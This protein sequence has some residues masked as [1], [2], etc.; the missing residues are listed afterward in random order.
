MP[1]ERQWRSGGGEG[2]YKPTASSPW[3]DYSWELYSGSEIVSTEHPDYRT[4]G[5][6]DVGGY[7][8]LHK[9][10]VTTDPGY[11]ESDRFQGSITAGTN[12]FAPAVEPFQ[13]LTD[14]N[15]IA[16]GTDAI[17][18]VSPQPA[19]NLFT[20][21]GELVKDGIPSLLGANLWREQAHV[22][23]GAGKE[24]L[25]SEFGWLPLIRDV[26]SFAKA[27]VDADE[28][29]AQYRSD[30]GTKI[31]RRYHYPVV[32]ETS[33]FTGSGFLPIPAEL[34]EF[35]RGCVIK[36]R[37]HAEWFSGAFRYH[38]PIGLDTSSK[39][40]EHRSL[41][42]QILGSNLT[43]EVLWN[44]TPWSWAIDW[45]TN[46]GSVMSNISNLGTDGLVM[47]YGYMMNHSRYTE[48]RYARF[49]DVLRYVLKNPSLT[50][51]E[52]TKVRLPSSPYGFGTT[53]EGL[54][55]RQ[56]SVLAALGLSRR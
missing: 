48:N 10:E 1:Q 24:F 36:N 30:S 40:A 32:S 15:L 33:S 4:A 42:N 50:I 2:R 43:P 14:A 18:R 51:Q 7:F 26:K 47:E 46:T 49:G 35:G 45:F 17:S 9:Y 28:T 31:R 52:E 20:S 13:R 39:L 55:P 22:A 16:L 34:N 27:V 44:L 38:V 25:N 54:S 3:Y 56:V 37:Y 5:G 21:V 8:Y 29:I 6:R 19:F 11:I 23:R 12:I 53:W 41:A